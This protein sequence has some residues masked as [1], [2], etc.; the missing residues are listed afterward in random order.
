MSY[1]LE[2][3]CTAA[4]RLPFRVVELAGAQTH[5]ASSLGSGR[6]PLPHSPLHQSLEAKQLH[7]N[8]AACSPHAGM[9]ASRSG[10]TRPLSRR[11][12]LFA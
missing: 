11:P 9:Q 12:R 5:F 4:A 3:V 7:A 6:S 2:C 8:P 1:G 10:R